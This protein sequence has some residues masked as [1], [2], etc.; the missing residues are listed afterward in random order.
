MISLKMK[1]KMK[2]TRAGNTEFQAQAMEP[3]RSRRRRNFR[4]YQH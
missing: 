2:M 4:P 3:L 1:M